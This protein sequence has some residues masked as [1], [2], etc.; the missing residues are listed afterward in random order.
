MF[1]SRVQS[2]RWLTRMQD[3]LQRPTAK[4]VAGTLREVVE[5]MNKTETQLQEAAGSVTNSG[6]DLTH[7]QRQR[8]KKKRQQDLLDAMDAEELED[9]LLSDQM[10]M[11]H[12]S[13]AAN[14]SA[15]QPGVR[16]STTRS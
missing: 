16:Q 13:S 6:T 1:Q 8:H 11:E 5:V 10:T 14:S 9:L 3:P 12:L 7:Q 2:E 15:H 4:Q